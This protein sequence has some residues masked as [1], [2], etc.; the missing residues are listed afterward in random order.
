MRDS[1][2]W[3]CLACLAVIFAAVR[4]ASAVPAGAAAPA[5]ARARLPFMENTGWA[6]QR[7]AYAVRTM[8]GMVYV[9]HDGEL[10]YAMPRAS[11]AAAGAAGPELIV[12][13][14]L[15]ASPARLCG[16]QPA[17]TRLSVFHG[18]DPQRWQAGIP[19]FHAVEWREARPGLHV[20]WRACGNNVEKIFTFMPGADPRDLQIELA[21]AGA[22]RVDADG[23]LIAQTAQ[24]ELIFTAPAAYQAGS[25]GYEP[26]AVRYAVCGAR[27]GFA[28]GAYDPARPLV[29]DPLLGGTYLGGE[30]WDRAYAMALDSQGRVYIAGSTSSLDFPFTPGAFQTNQHGVFI[31]LFDNNLTNLIASTFLGGSGGESAC[32]VALDAAGRVYVAGTTGSTNFPTTAGAYQAE[33]SPYDPDTP[34]YDIFIAALSADLSQLQACTLLGGDGQDWGQTLALDAWTN[35]YVA[36]V[37][38]SSNFPTTDGAFQRALQGYA[39]GFIAKFDSGLT[40]LTAAT[41]LG[42]GAYENVASIKLHPDGPVYAAGVT[43]STN[44]PAINSPYAAALAGGEDCFVARLDA[45]LQTLQNATYLGGS[46]NEWP[47]VMLI[48]SADCIYLAG[49]TYSADF[50]ATVDAWQ[51][52]FPGGEPG[53][54]HGFLTRMN[55]GLSV[56]HNS[57]FLGGSAGYSQIQTIL[58]DGSGDIWAAG[59]TAASNFPTTPGA[60]SRTLQIPPGAPYAEPDCFIARLGVDL[61]GLHQ[62]TLLG[63]RRA[64][65]AYAMQLDQAGNVFAAGYTESADFPTA[66]GSY[67]RQ[68][69]VPLN[70]W[71]GD[72][73]V[74]KL[75]NAMGDFPAPPIGVAASDCVYADRIRL[76]WTAADRTGGYTVWR[77][78][79][80][81]TGSAGLL[82]ALDGETT[83]YIDRTAAPG[84]FYYYWIKA[85]NAAG[86]SVFSQ[87]AAGRRSGTVPV[88]ADFDGDGLADPAIVVG[89]FW[90]VWQSG[91]G[92]ALVGPVLGDTAN[93]TFA[94][95]D[96]DGDGR[97][98]PCAMDGGGVWKAWLSRSQYAPL[99]HALAAAAGGAAVAADFD[100][101]G[102]A[103]PA[104]YLADTWYFW[105]SAAAYAQ[106]AQFTVGAYPDAIALAADFD[107]DGKADPALFDPG[108]GSWTIWLS[109]NWYEA[110]SPPLPLAEPGALPAAGDFDGDGRADIAAYKL[111][112]GKWYAWLSGQGYVRSGPYL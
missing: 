46:T 23:R 86:A 3:W 99:T 89:G 40:H 91:A 47:N 25:M 1:H 57:T 13:K 7:V 37:T 107:G 39:D 5:L 87:S 4:L 80:S 18:A 8:A 49:Y 9:T 63:G 83:A 68:Y 71:H 85:T 29:I 61:A 104:V 48:G 38:P 41:L 45:S 72:A 53:S 103:D 102:L 108:T 92:Y 20:T 2:G 16:R 32:A 44:F 26:V 106:M 24:G 42:G 105:M 73:F 93:R 77:G 59:Y 84:V 88:A 56:V 62:S 27:Y 81:D 100:G 21:G 74:S 101:D 67:E 70:F 96:F 6:D 12:E 64:D 82:A 34:N 111:G 19:A 76:S 55:A 94:A 28:L 60:Y 33:I 35:V 58:Q 78:L 52:D 75:D 11:S 65:Y 79:S 36:G 17:A 97:A 69:H 95:G 30:D 22:L 98:D 43:M 109:D 66:P 14:L 15:D 110:Y 112:S 50:P 10:L 54:Y 31:S 51:P 90:Q